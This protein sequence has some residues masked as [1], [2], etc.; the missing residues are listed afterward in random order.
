MTAY[1]YDDESCTDDEYCNAVVD[2]DV[3]IHG[4]EFSDDMNYE[5]ISLVEFYLNLHLNR[6]R[7]DAEFAFMH[8]AD[9]YDM[10]VPQKA[11]SYTKQFQLNK[12]AVYYDKKLQDYMFDNYYDDTYSS[13]RDYMLDLPQREFSEGMMS[14]NAQISASRDGNEMT[15][16]VPFY[17][18]YM[19][20]PIDYPINMYQDNV[21]DIKR[22]TTAVSIPHYANFG[23]VEKVY[24]DDT[25]AKN[26]S[27]DAGCIVVL[28]DD[29]PVDM[30]AQNQW[31]GM[32]R[33]QSLESKLPDTVDVDSWTDLFG[34]RLLW[35]VS[36]IGLLYVGYRAVR[37]IF[38]KKRR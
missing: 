37:M 24:V 16:D 4:I 26:T 2:K 18:L 15:V 34:L 28:P 23:S 20:H 30:V 36:G 8:L 5:S 17:D 9:L 1:K 6:L 14:V 35:I 13:H 12:T 38:A 27:C 25:L 10:N 21:L 22:A 19:R 33:K 32:I 7:D 29:S 11:D 31:G 3:T